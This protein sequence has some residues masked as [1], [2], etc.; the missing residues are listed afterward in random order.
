MR[1]TF[2]TTLGWMDLSRA[3]KASTDHHNVMVAQ[4]RLDF[5]IPFVHEDLP[6]YVDPFLLWRSPSQQDQALHEGLV[7]AFNHL[8]WLSRKGQRN[9]A[10][11]T[12]IQC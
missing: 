4:E 3:L 12:L 10:L 9:E 8:G 1:R 11:Q 2:T 7:G 6:L 5:V